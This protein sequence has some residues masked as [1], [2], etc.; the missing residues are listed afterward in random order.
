MKIP[1]SSE[2][3]ASKLITMGTGILLQ[4]ASTFTCTPI[5]RSLQSAVAEAGI[6]DGLG[7][8]QYGQLSEYMLGPA[9]DSAQILGT[10]VLLRVEDWLR[11]NLNSSAAVV[12]SGTG[13]SQTREELGRRTDEF[14]SQLGVLSRR[15]KQ[16]WFLA[17]PSK[18]WISECHKLGTLCQTYS[19]LLVARV[20]TLPQ[21][22][23]LN[24]PASLFTSEIDD[25]G[26]DRLGQIP[27]TQHSFDQLGQFVGSQVARTLVR[28]PPSV[29]APSFGGSPDLAAYLAGLHVQ[30]QLAPPG[31]GDRVHLDRILRAA[32]A[33]SLTGEDPDLSE[34]QIDTL[35][36]SEGCM[37]ISVSDRLSDHG[38]SG[39]LGF[40]QDDDSLVV[41]LMALSCTVLGEQVEYAVLSALAQIAIERHLAT[42][43]FEY[44]PSGRNQMML[45]FLQ[46]VTDEQPGMRCVLPVSLAETRIRGAA[47]CAEAWT[48]KRT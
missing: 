7:F 25:I 48:V 10:V 34:A 46:S 37:L 40:R 8:V 31:P 14:M 18:G 15:G 27:F 42:L 3:F 45:S 16:V 2:D 4:V 24:W 38:V 12:S 28:R 47:V 19:N 9:P 22:M 20:R 17:C 35:L 26:S 32:A 41:E 11:E 1:A 33:F 5:K 36:E 6:A 39:L 30:V 13:L 29:M 43:V 23:V 21:I 44:R